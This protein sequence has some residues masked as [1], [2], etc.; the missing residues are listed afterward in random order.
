V[1]NLIAKGTIEERMLDTLAAKRTVFAGVFGAGDAPDAISFED[2]GQGLLKQ[3]NELLKT[4]IEAE[5]QLQPAAPKVEAPIEVISP[6]PTLKG[7][8]DRLLA[9]LP[10]Q[11]MLV[12]TAPIGEGLL[13]VVNAAPIELRPAIEAELAAYYQ[14]DRPALH[15]MEPEGYRALAAFL[16]PATTGENAD[17]YRAAAL[18]S[19]REPDQSAERRHKAQQG[20]AFAAKRVA[21]AEVVLKG[22]FPEEMARPVREALGWGVSSLLALYRDH[23]PSADLPA[24]RLIQAE[25][26]EKQHLPDELA[27]RLSRAR[28]LTEP[29]LQG[30]TL[31][32]LSLDSGRTLL[33]DVQML[34]ELARQRI[35]EVSL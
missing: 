14:T 3:I 4:P 31:T 23:E 8:A 11:I 9:R 30:E 19:T 10:N 20:L 34:I 15:L 6:K 33:A 18:P 35:V 2:S 16:P 25:L 28:D 22:G 21:L 1:I 32:P 17:A 27:L 7:F 29:P 5:L 26:V 12:R 24:P 13:V